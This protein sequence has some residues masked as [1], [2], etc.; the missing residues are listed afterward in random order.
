MI[1]SIIENNRISYLLQQLFE[2]I[3]EKLREQIYN[4]GKNQRNEVKMK[5]KI[6]N[7]EDMLFWKSVIGLDIKQKSI[8]EKAF[9]KR[10]KQHDEIFKSEKILMRKS[11]KEILRS[12]MN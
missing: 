7:E 12:P 2:D 4:S 11:K 1:A 8:K 9:K 6:G 3:Q 10:I 5:M